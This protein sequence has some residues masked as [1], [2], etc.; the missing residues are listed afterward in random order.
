MSNK[1]KYVNHDELKQRKKRRVRKDRVAALVIGGVI[2]SAGAAKADGKAAA[3]QPAMPDGFMQ[4]YT[5]EQVDYG[6]TLSDIASYYYNEETH[7]S[8]FLNFDNYVET[9]A[10]T[11][12]ISKNNISP[13]QNLIIPTI[14]AEDNIY[15]QQINN[16]TQQLETLEKWVPHKIEYNDTILSLSYLGAGDTNEAY[17]IKN[18]ILQRN[19]INGTTIYAG[20]TIEIINPKIG[21]IKKE[22]AQLNDKLNQ[23][24]KN[25]NEN[26]NLNKI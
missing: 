1:I 10:T 14:V 12:N 8:Y 25:Q 18:S 15:L 16:L 26:T 7:D 17:E 23:S 9:I 21:E 13:F 11:N 2:L 20:D 6:E 22:I 5:T 24:L 4:I 19:N 3:A